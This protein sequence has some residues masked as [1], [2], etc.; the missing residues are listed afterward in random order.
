MVVIN[1]NFYDFFILFYRHRLH[2]L[3]EKEKKF[4]LLIKL[5]LIF[6][7]LKIN[8]LCDLNSERILIN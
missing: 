5:T 6:A 1:V 3:N 7:M 2:E 8:V 4:Q